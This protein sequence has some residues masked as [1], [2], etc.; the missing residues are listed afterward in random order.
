MKRMWGRQ[1]RQGQSKDLIEGV[2]FTNGEIWVNVEYLWNDTKN[3]KKFIERFAKAYTHEFMHL[4]LDL[5]PKY[6]YG[7]ERYIRT[8]VDEDKNWSEKL[9]RFYRNDITKSIPKRQRKPRPLQH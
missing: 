4:F 2:A 8:Y 7:E 3:E 6:Q 5:P 9:E 1:L